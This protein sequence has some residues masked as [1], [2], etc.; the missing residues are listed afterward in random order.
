MSS[1]VMS[2]AMTIAFVSPRRRSQPVAS[3][4]IRYPPATMDAPSIQYAR[5]DDGVNIAYW[6]TGRG[7]LLLHEMLPA[8]SHL[9]F[10]WNVPSLSAWYEQLS[11]SFTVVRFDHRGRGLSDRNLSDLSLAAHLRDI[12]AVVAAV[13]MSSFVF[14]GAHHMG[15]VAISYTAT[16]SASVSH[17]VL[18]SSW[19]SGRDVRDAVD[20]SRALSKVDRGIWA[21]NI[22][23]FVAGTRAPEPE[24]LELLKNRAVDADSPSIMLEAFARFDVT[25]QLQHV[26][27]P[28]LVLYESG[29]VGSIDPA[30]SMAAGIPGA[31]LVA[32]ATQGTPFFTGQAVDVLLAALSTFAG[33]DVAGQSPSPT[34]ATP[35]RTILFTDLESST[36][37][38][39][40]IGDAKVQDI[41]HGHNDVVR[42]ALAAHDGEE[43]KHTGDGIM[44]SFGSAVS[45][46]E[47]A[48]AIQ[49]GLVGAE[50][51]VR[52]GLNAGEPIQEDGDLF[53]GSVQLAARV[54]DR[55]EPG[56]V[57]VSN[58]VRELCTGKMFRFADQ[59]EAMLKGFPEPVRLFTVGLPEGDA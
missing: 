48:L 49:R 27:V 10:E 18:L 5:T 54:C 37:L 13:G 21:E 15:P 24:L 2:S 14:L 53:G 17:L 52:V 58:V 29:S 20:A 1:R 55:A 22:A 23:R 39:Q 11:Q 28:T 36:A 25:D 45:A 31:K 6:V 35:I 34:A 50:V 43:V 19:A 4:L 41:L 59:G 56:Q 32:L 8:A 47:A 42:A 3:R 12:D 44:A 40:A 33:V 16:K 26:G 57:L 38:T 30:R 51:R 9:E 7:P 46:V